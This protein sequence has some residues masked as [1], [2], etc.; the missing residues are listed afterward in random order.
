[1]EGFDMLELKDI[2]KVYYVGEIV[3]R[4]LNGISIT[5]RERE[6][7]AI[8][9]ESGSGKTTGLNIIG[10]LDKSTSGE[11]VIKGRSTKHFSDKDWDAYRNN[12]VG[13]V[14]QNYNL[15]SHLS[16]VAN[17]EIGMT[18]SGVS[19][20]QKRRRAIEVLTQVGLKEHLHKKPNQLSGGQMQRVA[21]ARALANDPE[22]LLCDEPTGALD[23][24]TSTQIMEIIK[25]IAR[26]RLVIMVTHNAGL[27]E[28]YA[29]RIVR[30]KDGMIISDSNPVKPEEEEPKQK[31]FSLKR[32]SMSFL[33]A[34]S[35]SF[36]NL[37]TKKGRTFLTSLASS[38]GIIGIAVIL[39]LSNGFKLQVD[40][41][42]REAMAEF[43]IVISRSS[44]KIDREKIGQLRQ[45]LKEKEYTD[46]REVYL[47]DPSE[48]VFLHTNKITEE[49]VEYVKGI[50]PDICN[51]IGYVRLVGMNLVR[52]LGQ[53][54]YMIATV[55]DTSDT[56]GQGMMDSSS[57]GLSTYPTQLDPSRPSYLE[58]NYDLLAG[59]YPKNEYEMVLVVDSRNRVSINVLKNLRFDTEGVESVKFEDI[60]GVEFKL[61]ANDDFYIPM[62]ST[63]IPGNLKE[64]Y[65]SERSKSL[66]ISGIVRLKRDVEYG[67]L[68]PGIAYSDDLVQRIIDENKDSQIVVALK[69]N[70]VDSIMYQPVTDENRNYFLTM[71]GGESAPSAILVY[72]K[73]FDSK[74][75]ILKY[76]DEYND[77][78]E[79][80]EDKIFYTDL[81]GTISNMTS[82][83]MD[84]ITIV[85]IAF[86][87]IS[88]VVSLI[89]IGIITYTSVLERTKEIGI[90][91]ALGA[92]KKDIT[93][94]F[95][96][97]TFIIGI[98]SGVLGVA[99]AYLATFPINSLLEA[100]TGLIGVAR[101]HILHVVVLLV[102]ST[103]LTVLGGHIP[104]RMAS[105]KEAVEALR[106]E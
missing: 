27:A 22:I 30:F 48:N 11:L 56:P 104:A 15:I 21:I 87:S 97:E 95:D 38:I 40:K 23:S 86:A 80:D 17:V 29:T 37:K 96:A 31:G 59:N 1:M 105:R 71:L 106:S 43:P 19:R 88:L 54:N 72:P 13:F 75:K 83:I 78:F 82:G 47:Y 36:N 46:A 28:A 103:F 6:F 32:T 94:V 66:R 62:G 20:E 101:L 8:L 51:G 67:I 98:F 10:G 90:L 3:T 63:F 68:S 45:E 9:G 41:F 55:A 2:R 57:I 34:L 89:M 14:F 74:E 85:L 4:A 44:M 42:Q 39:S 35:L 102:L 93:R 73:D 69:E 33:T 49:Y 52:R 26:E 7:V 53:D 58:S 77:R 92:R 65:N 16:I 100:L 70:C 60:V 84:G 91:R 5:F 64:M 12:S 50:D 76:L 18:L 99:I 24:E 25:E 79:E 81:A 61:I